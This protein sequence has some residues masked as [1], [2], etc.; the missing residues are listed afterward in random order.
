M[1][2]LEF[3]ITYS[4]A[5]LVMFAAGYIIGSQRAENEAERIRRWWFNR[6]RRNENL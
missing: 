6:E 3:L 2:P 1:T 4:I 5:G